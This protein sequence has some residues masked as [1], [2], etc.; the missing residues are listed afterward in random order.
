MGRLLRILCLASIALLSGCASNCN[1]L[2]SSNSGG[3]DAMLMGGMILAAPILAP[4]AL[5][6]DAASD[7]KTK[8]M[9]Q[10]WKA[11]METRLAANDLEAIQE[12]LVK[13]ES[14]W[15]Y[16]LDYSIRR[17][18]NLDAAT[19]LIAGNWPGNPSK[20]DQA[21]LLLAHNALSWQSRDR[22]NDIP[23]AL[24]PAEVT[25][26]YSLLKDATT[27]AELR[28]L[29]SPSRYQSLIS[30]LYGKKFAMGAP[31]SD[32]AAHTH[33]QQCPVKMADIALEDESFLGRRIACRYAYSYRFHQSLPKEME[34]QWKPAAS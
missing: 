17:Q 1:I 26:S 25:R 13:C 20:P 31:Q 23:P 6:S 5:F 11:S 34:S 10:E 22:E 27:R 2:S 8:R 7:A 14:A 32:E 29:L 9:A 15:K 24:V 18:L 4:V 19:R 16:E 33:F 12:C 21:Y 3:C 30:T 28:K